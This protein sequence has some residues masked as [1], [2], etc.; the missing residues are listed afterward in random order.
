MA[1]QIVQKDQPN[2]SQFKSIS[3]N[4]SLSNIQGIGVRK[5]WERHDNF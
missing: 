3:K 5:V 4:Y 2:E 1:Q